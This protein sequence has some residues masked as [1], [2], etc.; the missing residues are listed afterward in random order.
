[1]DL[2]DDPAYPRIT[3]ALEL[4]GMKKEDISLKI[5]DGNLLVWGERRARLG[6]PS[7]ISVQHQN[8][9][10]S[11]GAPTASSATSSTSATGVSPVPHVPDSVDNGAPST[12]HNSDIRNDVRRSS[13][14][15]AAVAGSSQ[16]RPTSAPNPHSNSER[17]I[18][19]FPVQELKYGKFRR[20]IALPNGVQ[21][22]LSWSITTFHH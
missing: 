19:N 2:H 8:N 16:I 18:A 4:P 9:I 5:Q 15:P 21:V 14:S 10:S 1:M 13:S 20:A 7:R 17:P 12:S 22:C 6:T 3:A 11:H